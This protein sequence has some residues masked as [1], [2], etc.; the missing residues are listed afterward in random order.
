M[1]V[2][3]ASMN[4]DSAPR[5][6][7]D[8]LFRRAAVRNPDAVALADPDDRADYTGGEPRTMTYAQADRVIWA[9]A[10][11]LR[12]LGLQT[13]SVI[14]VQLPNTREHILTLLGILR[15]GM[16]AS[17]LPML[18]RETEII[19]ALSGVGAK[20]IITTSRIGDTDH[21]AV[22]GSVAAGLFS[23]RHICAF[24][25]L[26]AD[27]T[28]PLHDVFDTKA[29]ME[30]SPARDGNPAAH[31]AIVTFEPT[32]RGILP[33]AR[34]HLQLIAAGSAIAAESGMMQ[35]SS[36]LSA[37]PP[38]SFAGLAVTFCPWLLTGGRLA[39]HQPF[40]GNLFRD[41]IEQHGCD[42]VVVPGPLAPAFGDISDTVRL[43]AVW[44]QPE[45]ASDE[46][47]SPTVLD[48]TA[49]GEFGLHAALRHHDR[50]KAPL[51]LGP[52][53]A[54][55][56]DQV[57]IETRRS[58]KGTL[59]LSGAMVAQ[60]GFAATE[61]A[62]PPDGP[63]DTGYPCRIEPDRAALIITGP[64]AGMI[65][66]GGYRIARSE[67][68]A[69]SATLPPDSRIAALPDGLLGQRLRGGAGQLA[70]QRVNPLI[71]S[72]AGVR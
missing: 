20:A 19:A 71:A 67:I 70:A 66:I 32:P 13:D 51:P 26:N 5:T 12:I 41:Q 54:A 56:S 47:L 43:I 14:G 3:A 2:G 11:R 8:E 15:A 55:M 35:E 44:R 22:A 59:L 60:P 23:I 9:I 17:P 65:G 50:S 29:G 28:V 57:V 63:A 69:L 4:D 62:V 48:V 16:I 46:L 21:C 64:Q 39:L 30:P 53:R 18:W 24:G 1:I 10:E 7:L 27:G 38:S 49:F 40:D 72:A 25:G 68:D 6:T 31:A 34:N 36:V 42:T 33:V 45:R 61:A 52:V 37:T 58:A